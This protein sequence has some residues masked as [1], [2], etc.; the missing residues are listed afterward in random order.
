MSSS[1]PPSVADIFKTLEYGPAPE[2]GTLFFPPFL[3]SCLK[4]LAANCAKKWFED[5]QGRF[6]HFINNKWEHPVVFIVRV[7]F[8]FLPQLVSPL[9]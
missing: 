5:H 4:T 9:F 6:G 8:F 1:K 7:F 2:E 3:Q